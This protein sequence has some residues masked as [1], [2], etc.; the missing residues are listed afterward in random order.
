MPRHHMDSLASVPSPQE[1][2]WNSILSPP[3][4]P[5][6]GV[7]QGDPQSPYLFV[8]TMERLGHAIRWAMDSGH[9]IPF[10][11][12]RHGLPLSHLFFV[13]DLILYAKADL[14]QAN[15]ISSILTEFGHFSG[16]R[17]NIQKS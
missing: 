16:H 6:R 10:R 11:L 5:E 3:F 14:D 1:V 12:A 9:W 17:V 7:R 13:D 15:V 2:Q 4:S 8:L